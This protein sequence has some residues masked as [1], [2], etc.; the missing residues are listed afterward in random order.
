M[1]CLIEKRGRA[2]LQDDIGGSCIQTWQRST[3][4]RS[5]VQLQLAIAE[6]GWRC[7]KGFPPLSL[8]GCCSR[9]NFSVH[10]PLMNRVSLYMVLVLILELNLQH[11]WISFSIFFLKIFLLDFC[12]SW[13]WWFAF[14]SFDEI[15]VMNFALLNIAGL[16]V[17]FSRKHSKNKAAVPRGKTRKRDVE[18]VVMN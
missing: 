9:I 18:Q 7:W 1:S 6:V 8:Y 15:A 17:W 13:V 11:S 14:W 3:I 4:S 10:F 16:S 12:L 5:L 2:L